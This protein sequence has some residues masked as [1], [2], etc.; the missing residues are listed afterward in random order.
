M[1]DLSSIVYTV[2]I[3]ALITALLV[4]CCIAC[5]FEIVAPG[6]PDVRN[7]NIDL[8]RQTILLQ[9][10]VERLSSERSPVRP[11]PTI[12]GRDIPSENTA[13]DCVIC[14]ENEKQCVVVPCG[15]FCLCIKCG[16]SQ[17]KQ[18]CSNCSS[19]NCPL[20]THR[21]PLCRGTITDIVRV[22]K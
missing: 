20:I 17:L 11:R 3:T 13:N 19:S 2:I 6:A 4:C 16:N 5:S 12:S 10:T 21:C 9:K 1:S 8:L 15:H 14:A 18:R 7:L 22:F